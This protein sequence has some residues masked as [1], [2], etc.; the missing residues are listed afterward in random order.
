MSGSRGPR[1]AGLRLA[2]TTFT[3]LPV[4][5]A[6]WD[7]STVRTAM[8]FAPAVGVL[9]GGLTAGVARALRLALPGGAGAL[10]VA[11]LAVSLLALLT[12]G[13]H[14]DGLADTVDALGSYGDRE[15][16][17]TIMKAP[18]VGPF[19]VVTV[20]VAILIDVAAVAVCIDAGHLAWALVTAPA[21]GRAAVPMS[22][23]RRTP[24]A[25]SSGL[26]A[27]VAGTVT[28]P[29]AFAAAGGVG[30][31]ASGWGYAADGV[32]GAVRG[33]VAVVAA[34][35]VAHAVRAHAV[36][37]LGGVTGDVLGALVELATAIA[38]VV[39]ATS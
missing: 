37:R 33:A 39:L 7:R 17:L 36:R 14:L 1:G 19:G 28:A 21:I 23:T 32:G 35:G 30:A 15:Q 31:I 9:L 20:V 16:A 5:S 26:G 18:D 25:R 22:C 11:V 10:L 6:R 34:L 27:L 12:R 38:L 3:V 29:A 2:L 4:A 8:L 13:L 24:A